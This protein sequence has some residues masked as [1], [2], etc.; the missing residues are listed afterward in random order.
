[1]NLILTGSL[2][3][4]ILLSGCEDESQTPI[5]ASENPV[6]AARNFIDAKLDRRWQEARKFI[7]PNATNAGLIEK[8][9]AFYENEDREE[10]RG[11]RGA[12]IITYDL[13]K[14]S[15][16]ASI[17]IFADSF[18]KQKDSVKVVRQNGQWLVDLGFSTLP[19]TPAK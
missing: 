8:L 15:D 7:L 17:Y 1:M 14:L 16:T 6:D 3:L 10:R 4:A 19:T 12:S 13:K 5:P 9:E 2:L 18:K 11:Y